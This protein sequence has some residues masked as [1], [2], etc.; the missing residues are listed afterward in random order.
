ME[1]SFTAAAPVG[2]SEN[3]SVGMRRGARLSLG[4]TEHALQ[5]M[6]AEFQ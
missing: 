5:E 4:V 6:R 2:Q 1:G 3:P